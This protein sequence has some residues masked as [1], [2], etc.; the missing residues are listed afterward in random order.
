MFFKKSDY[1]L[2]ELYRIGKKISN[3][4][5]LK[6]TSCKGILVKL[7]NVFLKTKDLFVV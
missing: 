5:I 3:G 4:K 6:I 1:E 2:K 7:G